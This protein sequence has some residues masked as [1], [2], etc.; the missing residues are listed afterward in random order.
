MGPLTES[1]VRS[2]S[3][4]NEPTPDQCLIWPTPDSWCQVVAS[5]MWTNPM[6]LTVQSY[7]IH[8][9]F[10][11]QLQVALKFPFRICQSLLTPCLLGIYVKQSTSSWL[12]WRT[13]TPSPQPCF[14]SLR[15]VGVTNCCRKSFSGKCVDSL[16][17]ATQWWWKISSLLSHSTR[18]NHRAFC[19]MNVCTWVVLCFPIMGFEFNDG[20]L[21]N[22]IAAVFQLSIG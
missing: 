8:V 13:P 4:T 16:L 11:F 19:F 21:L 6:L 1:I 18:F 7:Q 3:S 20:V 5:L 9:L 10:S 12:L 14:W 2:G 15:A 22:Q 17:S